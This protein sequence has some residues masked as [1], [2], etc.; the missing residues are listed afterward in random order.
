MANKNNTLAQEVADFLEG[1]GVHIAGVT[2]SSHVSPTIPFQSLSQSSEPES[3]ENSGS[4]VPDRFWQRVAIGA[5]TE[6]WMWKGSV[7]RDGYGRATLNGKPISASRA[8]YILATGASVDGLL[9]CHHCDNPG[10]CNPAHLYAGT[11]SDNERDKFLR[12]RVTM[13]GEKNNS[14]KLTA[15]QV[16]HVRRLFEQGMTNTAIGK[17]LNVHHSTIS[18]IRTGGS[19]GQKPHD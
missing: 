11:K 4:G 9:V 19:W 15:E 10:C 16:E 12:G 18:K 6:C 8:A 13:A 7:N 1:N 3:T 2:C 14:A 17:M 5:P